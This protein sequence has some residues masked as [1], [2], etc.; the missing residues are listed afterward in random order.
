MNSEVENINLDDATL[1]DLKTAFIN[2]RRATKAPKTIAGYKHNIDRFNDFLDEY[3]M[4][5]RDLDRKSDI[6]VPLPS[7]EGGSRL[8]D[9][10]L[11]D[12]YLTWMNDEEDY[13]EST[14]RSGF[15]SLRAFINYLYEKG[16]IE[17]N[18]VNDI[19]LGDYIDYD[20]T[21]QKEEFS[22]SYVAITDEEHKEMLNNVP[23]PV[24]RNKLILNILNETGIRRKELAYIEKDEVYLD[25]RRIHIPDVKGAERNVWFSNSLRTNLEIWIDVKRKAYTTSNSKYLFNTTRS[26]RISPK[27]V[28]QIVKLAAEDLDT[29]KTMKTQSGQVRGRI[30]THS[31]RHGFAERFL[32]NNGDIYAL[33]TLLGH[34]SMSQTEKYL[35]SEKREYLR[36]QMMDNGF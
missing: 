35:E 28:G 10:N 13:A 8:S 31:Y 4:D 15:G 33:K 14:V 23:N 7:L 29:Q 2:G 36:K 1:E 22:E 32:G 30:S 11:L 34:S 21:E 16:V 24:F 3:D 12:Y 6:V 18:P 5:L 26:E 27:R 17:Y 9:L 20:S 19:K 25:E